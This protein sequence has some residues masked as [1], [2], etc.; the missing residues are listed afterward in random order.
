MKKHLYCWRLSYS[1]N[2]KQYEGEEGKINL[3][4]VDFS[5][6]TH[7]VNNPMPTGKPINKF[8]QLED[9]P[10]EMLP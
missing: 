8:S 2:Q 9:R 4:L 1:Y 5:K 10:E 7:K 6:Y 3:K